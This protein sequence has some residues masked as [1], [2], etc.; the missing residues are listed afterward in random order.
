MTSFTKTRPAWIEVNLDNIVHNIETIEKVTAEHTHVLSIVK[1]DGYKF[2]AVKIVEALREAGVSYFGVATMSEAVSLRNHFDDISILILGY[3]PDYLMEE[4]IEKNITMATYSMETAK[5]LSAAAKK[6]GKKAR[7]HLVV[8]SGMNRI[9]FKPTEESLDTMVEISKLEGIDV[10]GLFTHFAVADSDEAFTKKQFKNYCF[11]S[12]GLRERGVDIR[13]RHVSNSHAI[14][15]YREFDLDFVRPGVLQYG[16]KEGVDAPEFDVRFIAEVK[17]EI[18]HLKTVGAGEGV[19][20]GLTYTTEKETKIATLPLGYAD[21]I[22]RLLSNKIDVLV[23]GKRC[24]QIGRICMDQFMIDVT[25]VDCKVGDEVVIV[26]KQGEEE[27]TIEE[28]S[29]HAG[30]IPTSFVTHF[31]KRLPKVYLRHGEVV[32]V[33]DLVREL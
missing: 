26:G 4:A 30:E 29:A 6:L 18:G 20:Y 15:R 7:I 12:E 17:A 21:G 32:A 25:G 28:I 8:D 3:T 31:N 13:Y 16:S 9:G 10:E 5:Q 23:G 2:G 27:I 11:I 19:S 33:E 22:P 24:P 1:S 14:M